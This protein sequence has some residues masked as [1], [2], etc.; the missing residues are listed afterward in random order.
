MGAVSGLALF[1]DSMLYVILP[2]YWEEAGLTSLWQ[3][4][5]ILSMNRFVRLPLNPLIG[6]LYNR[7]TLRTGLALAT[8]VGAFTTIGYGVWKGFAAWLILRSLW[9]FAWSLLRMGGYLT[10]IRYSDDSNRGHLM[11][12]YNGVWRLGSLVGVL[13][14]GLLVPIYG[15][16]NV[17]IVFGS[18]AVLGLPIIAFFITKDKAQ[19]N[20][21]QKTGG[22]A[23]K[24]ISSAWTP[25]VKRMIA[26][27]FMIAMLHAVFGATLSYL[28]DD[29]GQSE[30]AVAGIALSS[31]ALAGL[32]QALRCL[33]EPFLGAFIG[34]ISDGPKGRVP[35]FIATL[36][37]S[38]AG[39]ALMPW[40]LPLEVWLLTV[41]YVMM[42][43]T[44]LGTLLDAMAADEAKGT[45]TVK[46]ITA[47]TVST[48]LGAAVGPA[49]AYAALGSKYGITTVYIASAV[50]FLIIGLWFRA[51]PRLHAERG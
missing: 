21:G 11:G 26:S 25:R 3:V 12:R 24:A 19:E 17:S 6:W 5:V 9:G 48:D 7:I 10:V 36:A 51:E 16:A 1:G 39:Y 15:L 41:V 14:G 28:I 23:A 31:A 35:L 42:T 18:L 22:E 32:L 49:L 37:A 8:V 50:L 33:W 34:G 46:T 44:A 13:F 45:S 43:T 4:G 40:K 2:I 27:G 30:I 29:I 47:Y 38:A 20:T